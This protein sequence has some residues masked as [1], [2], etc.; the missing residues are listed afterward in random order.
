MSTSENRGEAVGRHVT[1]I[2]C[3][4]KSI[5]INKWWKEVST[6]GMVWIYVYSLGLTGVMFFPIYWMIQELIKGDDLHMMITST[7]AAVASSITLILM[8]CAFCACVHRCEN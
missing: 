6:C 7:F 4:G 1:N 3:C 5:R 8:M 2:Q